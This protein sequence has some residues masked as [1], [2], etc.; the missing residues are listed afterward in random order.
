[1][2]RQLALDA[3]IL[4]GLDQAD[5]EVVLPE[6]IHRHA[7]RTRSSAQILIPSGTCVVVIPLRHPAAL[8]GIGQNGGL[9]QR[10]CAKPAEVTNHAES[11]NIVLA[12]GK[13]RRAG[14]VRHSDTL[15]GFFRRFDDYRH[16]RI[17]P[18]F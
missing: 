2:R 9:R 18:S 1:M 8:P 4:R 7:W 3:E 5:A 10:F 14:Y 11:Y 16:A 12:L 13:I 15:E 6:A 17:I